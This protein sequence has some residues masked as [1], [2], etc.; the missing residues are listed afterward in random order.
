[1]TVMTM[2]ILRSFMIE[3]IGSKEAVSWGGDHARFDVDWRLILV[4]ERQSE[5]VE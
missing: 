5:R 1:M 4:C 3:D 2:T